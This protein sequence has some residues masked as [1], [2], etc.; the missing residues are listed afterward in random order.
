MTLQW[1]VIAI[2]VAVYGFGAFENRD[3]IAEILR[4]AFRNSRAVTAWTVGTICWALLASWNRRATLFFTALVALICWPSIRKHWKQLPD[5][6]FEDDESVG[7][8]QLGESMRE[9]LSKQRDRGGRLVFAVG[10]H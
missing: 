7:D 1:L 2:A 3:R 10:E 4:L 8:A 5:E 6:E 9:L